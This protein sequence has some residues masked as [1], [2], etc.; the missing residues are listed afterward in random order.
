MWPP[1]MMG[2]FGMAP[3]GM[4]WPM[5]Y[6]PMPFPGYMP[7]DGRSRPSRSRSP[8]CA[9][10]GHSC[11]LPQARKYTCKFM[12]GIEN[13]EDFRVV[14]RIIGSNGARM[15]EIV[16]KSGGDAK[17]RLRGRGSG[18]MERDT[19]AESHE[20]L[21]L[22]ISCPRAE[23]YRIAVGAAEELLRSVY[24]EYAQ[25]CSARSLQHT[26]PRVHMSERHYTAGM[27]GDGSPHAMKDAGHGPKRWKNRKWKE[28]EESAARDR[29]PPAEKDDHGD[30]PAGA[31]SVEMIERQVE[32]R[33]AARRQG[34]FKQADAIRRSLKESG[35]V[36]SD[37]KGGH[38]NAQTVTSWR[39]WHP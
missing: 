2:H 30:A 26:V 19:K 24:E 20:A 13:E 27:E 34:D 36:L 25:W 8:R 14:R 23:G 1:G 7:P 16:A 5:G 22:C 10:N 38:G 12:I 6:P 15:K 31:P 11:H 28:V 29:S 39:Y 3:P 21:Q 37:E 18:Y 32:A 35:V 17:L 33:N 9:A 4:P